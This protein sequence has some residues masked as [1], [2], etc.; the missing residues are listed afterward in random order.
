MKFLIIPLTLFCCVLMVVPTSAES[1]QGIPDD[2]PGAFIFTAGVDETTPDLCNGTPSIAPT[3]N[4]MQDGLD[5]DILE[6]A[7]DTPAEV[8][9]FTAGT[10]DESPMGQIDTTEGQINIGLTAIDDFGDIS[11]GDDDNANLDLGTGGE[12]ITSLREPYLAI[13]A[14]GILSD[15][16]LGG[17]T[18]TSTSA[19]VADSNLGGMELFILEDGEMSGFQLELFT[20]FSTYIFNFD[21]FQ[22]N[23]G[24]INGADDILYGIDLDAIPDWDGTYL[25]RIKMID[26]GITQV[27][28]DSCD[29]TGSMDTSLEIDA[30]LT[31]KTVT[32]EIIYGSITGNV[33][34]DT[35]FDTIGENPLVGITLQLFGPTGQPVL[36]NN[37]DPITTVTDADG[38]Y[39]FSDVYPADYTVVELQPGAYLDVFEIEGGD[40]GDHPD[41]GILNS[42]QVTVDSG[43]QD[44]GNNF[45]ERL[46][47]YTTVSIDHME[48]KPQ[49]TTILAIVTVG[50]LLTL[51]VALRANTD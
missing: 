41:N 37:G 12:F 49:Q 22:V 1:I 34:E 2:T 45:V 42:I 18:F 9:G 40:D 29:G 47:S 5:F 20:P 38:N 24:T 25:T 7:G 51:T 23:P 17:L 11:N 6:F 33:S 10:T 50:L 4:I 13:P 30:I 16:V 48:T 14:D 44:T 21:D 36:D 15:G 8:L 32:F 43:E 19:S 31:R 27:M 46:A 26:D 35:T 28:T 39:I 3:V